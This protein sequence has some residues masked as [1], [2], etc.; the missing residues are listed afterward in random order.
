VQSLMVDRFSDVEE[1]AVC[2]A[3]PGPQVVTAPQ[4]TVKGSPGDYVVTV[5]VTNRAPYPLLATVPENV[6]SSWLSGGG[7]DVQIPKPITIPAHGSS[8]ISLAVGV[9]NCNVAVEGAQAGYAFDVL[10][11]TDARDGPYNPMSRESDED[12]SLY[13]SA[14]IKSYCGPPELPGIHSSGNGHLK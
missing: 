3:M 9:A 2:Q 10:A 7:L 13:D 8:R 4:V 11:F 14:L 5:D 12:F 1:V 6:R